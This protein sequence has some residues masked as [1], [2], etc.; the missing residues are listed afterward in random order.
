MEES[1]RCKQRS[2]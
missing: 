1:S 2:P